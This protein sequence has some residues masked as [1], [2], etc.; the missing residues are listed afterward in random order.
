MV[1]TGMA[2]T[3][4][5][6]HRKGTMHL[7]YFLLL[8]RQHLG[9][10]STSVVPLGAAL[11]ALGLA[12]GLECV[13]LLHLRVRQAKG[14]LHLCLHR[15]MVLSPFLHHRLAL[16]GP[17]LVAHPI[18]GATAVAA[19]SHPVAALPTF[20]A[21]EELLLLCLGKGRREVGSE[22]PQGARFGVAQGVF[23]ERGLRVGQVESLRQALSPVR[24]V[25]RLHGQEEDESKGSEQPAPEV[26]FH[27]VD[28]RSEGW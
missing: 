7:G 1:A 16:L 14:F 20:R 28:H 4:V 21:R 27:G 25:L 19:R 9:E 13:K 17:V 3:S 12:F 26:G 8:G 11:L 5:Q 6:P 23:D 10:F 22:L 18:T 24:V 15:L 2:A